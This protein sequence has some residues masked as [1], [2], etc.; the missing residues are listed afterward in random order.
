V[1]R[2]R[3]TISPKMLKIAMTTRIEKKIPNIVA[4]LFSE[5]FQD[6]PLVNP[7]RCGCGLRG[8]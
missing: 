3:I 6:K 7:L 2:T 1:R 5:R 4:G 8:A